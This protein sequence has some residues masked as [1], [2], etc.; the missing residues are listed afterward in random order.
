MQIHCLLEALNESMTLTFLLQAYVLGLSQ[1]VP[2]LV[3]NFEDS[4][5][6]SFKQIG[7]SL[8]GETLRIG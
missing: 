2:T 8:L 3:D 4:E 7:L 6:H 5:Q 1:N